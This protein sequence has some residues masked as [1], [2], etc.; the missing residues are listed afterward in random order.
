[1]GAVESVSLNQLKHC[2]ETMVFHMSKI[3]ATFLKRL[4][5]RLKRSEMF[6]F[7][8]IFLNLYTKPQETKL[9]KRLLGQNILSIDF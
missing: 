8:M 6:V 1:M 4:T 3:H 9:S 7:L 2:E 5:I